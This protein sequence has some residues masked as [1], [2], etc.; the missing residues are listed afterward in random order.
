MGLCLIGPGVGKLS[1]IGAVI[2]LI[3]LSVLLSHL[4]CSVKS[5]ERLDEINSELSSFK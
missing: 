2:L 1:I 4:W 5:K 3:Y